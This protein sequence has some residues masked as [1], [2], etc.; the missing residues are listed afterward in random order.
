VP[1]VTRSGGLPDAVGE[2]GVVVARDD[3][4]A[5]ASGIEALLGDAGLREALQARAADHLRR[6]T[7]ERI[8]R[9]Y[10]QVFDDA[11]RAGA[12]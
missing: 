3:P 7:P 2:C 4:A 5:L 9:D 6:H 10:L 8:A 11:C 1:L 12:R